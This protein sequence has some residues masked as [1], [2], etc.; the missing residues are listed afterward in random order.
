MEPSLS[1]PLSWGA[2]LKSLL[3]PNVKWFIWGHQLSAPPSKCIQY[4]SWSLSQ[5]EPEPGSKGI[6]ILVFLP[7]GY[8]F[9]LPRL[10]KWK[11][12]NKRQNFKNCSKLDRMNS[13]FSKGTIRMVGETLA[14]VT[15]QRYHC[16]SCRREG[17]YNARR[18]GL[19]CQTWT[20]PALRKGLVLG[21]WQIP[22]SWA[23]LYCNAVGCAR[24]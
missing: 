9:S 8:V 6:L 5:H 18:A 13:M 4:K 14:A 10:E 11:M 12:F 21:H 22:C 15:T 1:L 3:S 16:F 17:D 2:D 24:L 20:L 19:G 7:L 23:V